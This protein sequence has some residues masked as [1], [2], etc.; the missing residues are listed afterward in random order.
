MGEFSHNTGFP[1]W[2]GQGLGPGHNLLL[3]GSLKHGHISGQRL[4]QVEMP[5]GVRSVGESPA[6]FQ[7][8][9]SS[10]ALTSLSLTST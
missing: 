4:N 1:A 5:N 6:F 2:Q 10:F 8:D 7:F 3:D 9:Q